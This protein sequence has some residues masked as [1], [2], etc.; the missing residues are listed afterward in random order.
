MFIGHFAVAFAAKRAAPAASLGTLFLAAQFLDGLWPVF[1]LLGIE[2]VE[3]HPGDTAFTPL[4]FV[5]YPVSHSLAMT[6]VWAALFALAYAWFTKDRRAALV[7]AALVASHWVLDWLTHRPDLP[8]YPGGS[9]RVGLGLWNSV[10]ATLVIESL[11]FAAGIVVYLRA[12]RSR[13]RTGTVSFWMLIVF[14]I[15]AYL[16]AAFGPPPPDVQTLAWTALAG[17]LII[18]WGFWVDHHRQP[19]ANERELRAQ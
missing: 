6:L 8:L 12:T 9:A 5:H 19:S 13:D 16:G 3:I 4:N 10:A 17:W 2:R 7:A 18:A 11:M 15:A 14:L 1:L